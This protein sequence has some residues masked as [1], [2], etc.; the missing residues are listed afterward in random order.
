MS[1]PLDLPAIVAFDRALEAMVQQFNRGELKWD[2]SAPSL[3]ELCA[4]RE[5]DPPPAYHGHLN[6]TSGPHEVLRPR[7]PPED[8]LFV[9]HQTR[10]KPA[11]WSEL[12]MVPL[13]AASPEAV[14]RLGAP[15]TISRPPLT[16][17]LS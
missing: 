6:L 12:S 8:V 1:E 7:R 13:W 16:T 9:A 17:P 2:D 4:P 14:R 5:G 3:R 11:H 15:V 10:P